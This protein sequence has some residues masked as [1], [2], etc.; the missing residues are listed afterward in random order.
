MYDARM[1]E[2]EMSAVGEGERPTLYPERELEH[3]LTSGRRPRQP[4][5]TPVVDLRALDLAP[6]EA[7]PRSIRQLSHVCV[8]PM[9]QLQPLRHE[10]GRFCTSRDV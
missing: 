5:L 1:T 6:R 7:F 3:R 9:R 10:G 4:V 8:D 2:Q